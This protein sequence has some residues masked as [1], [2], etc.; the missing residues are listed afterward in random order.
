MVSNAI[1]MFL[2]VGILNGNYLSILTT[3]TMQITTVSHSP[4]SGQPA[5]DYSYTGSTSAFNRRC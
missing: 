2:L 1:L 5:I 4:S 3:A